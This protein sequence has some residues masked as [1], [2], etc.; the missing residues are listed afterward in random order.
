MKKLT[1]PIS[2]LE[3]KIIEDKETNNSFLNLSFRGEDERGRAAFRKWF[4]N[5]GELRALCTQKCRRQE[6]LSLFLTKFELSQLALTCNVHSCCDV[7]EL[8]CNCGNCQKLPF[9]NIFLD[10]DA[11]NEEP[12]E[13]V[14]SNSDTVSYKSSD[15][16]NE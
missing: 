3:L 9:E 8:S 12:S 7:C 10:Y 2:I 5:I 14:E 6:A 4:S 11:S 16:D 13:E 15:S 1:K